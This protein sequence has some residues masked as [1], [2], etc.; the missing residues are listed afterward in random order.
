[1]PHREQY[2]PTIFDKI[3]QGSRAKDRDFFYD[4]EELLSSIREH[5]EM[6]LN[7]RSSYHEAGSQNSTSFESFFSYGIS[8]YTLK[9]L[10][11]PDIAAEFAKEAQRKIEAFEHRLKNVIVSFDKPKNESQGSAFYLRISAILNVK[12]IDVEESS[13]T[14][15]SKLI[16][17]QKRFELNL[18]RP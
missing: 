12:N 6:L 11:Q 5:I 2:Q 15:N 4:K 8:D 13:L 10:N 7:N 3:T 1:M 9:D 17:N 14:F 16:P 18:E